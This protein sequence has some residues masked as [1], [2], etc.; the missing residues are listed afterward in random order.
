MGAGIAAG[1]PIVLSPHD[2]LWRKDVKREYFSPR[3]LEFYNYDEENRC[4]FINDQILLEN[5]Q[6][7]F[8]EFN[9]CIGEHRELREFPKLATYEEFREY[10]DEDAERG[11]FIFSGRMGFSI[12]GGI[13]PECWVFYNGSHKAFLEEYSTLTHFERVL[14][15]AM[16]NPL[17]NIVKF[18]ILG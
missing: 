18:G 4:Y 10:F 16:K 12:V 5:Y 3:L 14:V 11:P 1:I 8:T 13:C 9:D 17:A 15:R 7:F 2:R 6:S